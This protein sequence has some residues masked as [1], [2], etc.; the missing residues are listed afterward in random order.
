M[1]INDMHIAI[2]LELNKINSNLYDIFLPQEKDYFLNRAQERFVKQRYTAISNPKQRG[3][4][5][6][7]KRID[8]LRT[9]L[10]PNY[11]DKVYQLASSDFDFS[12]K[13]RFYFP[14]D[15]LFLTS[16]RSKVYYN[17]C[18]SITQNTNTE[19][20]NVALISIPNTT[21]TYASLVITVDGNNVFNSSLYPE[22]SSYT[23]EDKSLLIDLILNNLS[24]NNWS[25]YSSFKDLTA[26]IVGVK[27]TNGNITVTL[28]EES[29]SYN[30][31]VKTYTYFTASG[32]SDL[33]VPNRFIQQDDVYI[34]QQ[35]P[36][37][38]TSVNDGP[39]CIIH[40]NSI[41]VFFEPNKFIVKEIAISYIRK[42]KLMSLSNNQSCELAEH[43][44]AEIL[45]DA[46][47][48]ML[49]NIE[50]NPQ[51]LQTSMAVEQTNE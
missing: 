18:G 19:N 24:A 40:N 48:L 28:G 39:L 11:Y 44:H 21:S 31:A 9:L 5:M 2:D 34:V 7:Q 13:G 32:G 10:V 43:T 42:P 12:T 22:I 1:N 14:D 8:D 45:R 50:A 25:F 37:N 36:F 16:N 4:E 23:I 3:F 38:K 35:D 6:S 47:N 29:N 41:D 30:T 20:F 26:D 33:V 27:T 49:E 17:E 15:Y 51:R 46:V